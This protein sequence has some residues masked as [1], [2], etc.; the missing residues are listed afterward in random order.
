MAQSQTGS[1]YKKTPDAA[2]WTG[3]Y[4]DPFLQKRRV[5]TLFTDKRASQ[6]RLQELITRAERKAAGLEDPCVEQRERHLREHITEYLDHCRHVGECDTHVSNKK[7]QLERLM[8]DTNA[9]RLTDL[10]PNTVGRYL[11]RLSKGGRV[12]EWDKG[13]DATLSARSV[14][15]HRATAIALVNW[16]V[17]TNRLTDNPLKNVPKLDERRDRRR[18]RRAF[19]TEEIDR[20][21][22]IA[23]TRRP[24]YI[25]AILTGL[26]RSELGGI[27]WGDVDFD[28]GAIRVRIGVGKAR[29]ED[30]IPIHPQVAEELRAI[31]PDEAVAS[32]LVFASIPRDKTFRADLHR[33]EIEAKDSEGR[34]VDLHALRTTTG[35]MLARLGVMPQV[36]MRIMRHSDVKI[37]MKH[38]TDLRLH[39]GAKAIGMLPDIGKGTPNK[40]E[41]Q[42]ATGTDG[43]TNPPVAP[44]ANRPPLTTVVAP[45]VARGAPK[46]AIPFGTVHKPENPPPT[47]R[48]TESVHSGAQPRYTSALGTPVRSRAQGQSKPPRKLLIDSPLGAISAVG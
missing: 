24:V 47:L 43:P 26:R 10:T 35:T 30:F 8:A 44:G 17:D 3:A 9:T 37:T 4:F 15:H 38:Y 45:E 19:T 5:V 23:G 27:T 25:A 21:L 42:R 12:R 13:D 18:V 41:A 11:Q 28:G 40:P 29:R 20:L 1:L 34:V 31:K 39:D 16:C 36:A 7:S 14:N 33:A 32:D 2:K 22:A 48:L 46:G 6:V